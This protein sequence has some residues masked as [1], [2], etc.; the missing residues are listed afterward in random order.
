ML[1]TC[2]IILH[3]SN[4]LCFCFFL[5][6]FLSF[7]LFFILHFLYCSSHVLKGVIMNNKIKIIN[8]IPINYSK[9]LTI[10]CKI[11][12]IKNIDHISKLL[13]QI[14]VLLLHTREFKQDIQHF[15]P[16]VSS[17]IKQ[18]QLRYLME[19]AMA[20]HSSTLAWKIPW[21]EEPGRLQSLGSQRVGHN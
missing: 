2:I 9:A 8:L 6:F 1:K 14:L 4:F 7:S 3:C 16:L 19:K 5:C 12:V 18:R 21:M 13:V 15:C 11:S 17:T 20:P 10:P